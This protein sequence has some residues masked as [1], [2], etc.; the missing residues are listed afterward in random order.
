MSLRA[1]LLR[2]LALILVLSWALRS[3]TSSYFTPE[4]AFRA[5]EAAANYGPSTVA[6]VAEDGGTRWFLARYLDS[7]SFVP[8]SRRGP[9]GPSAAGPP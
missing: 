8:I 1:K 3:F 6:Y 9:S 7:W 4:G 5:S 2:N